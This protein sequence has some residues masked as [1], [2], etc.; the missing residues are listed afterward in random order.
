MINHTMLVRFDQPVPD[1]DLDQYLADIEKAARD[2]GAL[3]SFAARRHLPV[4]GEEQIP[5]FI[6]TIVVQLGLADLGALAT[7][8]AAPAVGE[9]FDRWRARHSY[10]VAWVNH[11]PLG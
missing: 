11:E 6:A 4:P 10:Q 5:G 7:L 1:A 8:F 3:H 9:V 2:T